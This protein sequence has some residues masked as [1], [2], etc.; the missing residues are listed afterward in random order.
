[1]IQIRNLSIISVEDGVVKGFRLAEELGKGGFVAVGKFVGGLSILLMWMR[2][3][4]FF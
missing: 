2:R 1:M 3:F 4:I